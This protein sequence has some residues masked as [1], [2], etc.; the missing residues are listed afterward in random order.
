[1]RGHATARGV[2]PLTR[3]VPRPRG[4]SRRSH[5]A[6]PR[7]RR[8]LA[9]VIASTTEILQRINARS[10]WFKRK[11]AEVQEYAADRRLPVGLT[12]RVLRYYRY[13]LQRRNFMEGDILADLSTCLRN[14]VVAYS[15]AKLI[16]RLDVFRGL[17]PTLITALAMRMRPFYAMPGE[18]I[19]REGDVSREVFFVVKGTVEVACADPGERA[20]DGAGSQH[21]ECSG[22]RRRYA[23]R[24]PKAHRAAAIC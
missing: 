20:D 8:Y 23:A 14:E 3:S 15:R 6:S 13:A 11:L 16:L 24:I 17:D 4:S 10:L 7:P 19:A 5:P 18:V 1:M 9:F 22:E 21:S 2:T 12:Q